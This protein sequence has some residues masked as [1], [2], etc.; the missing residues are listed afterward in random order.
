M[1]NFNKMVA[2]VV[3]QDCTYSGSSSLLGKVSWEVVQDSLGFAEG[4]LQVARAIGFLICSD[5][6]F[7]E[8]D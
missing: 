1:R 7:K 8:I 6:Y 4:V 3:P 5:D 2:D